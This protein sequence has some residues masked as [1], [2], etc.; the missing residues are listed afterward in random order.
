MRLYQLLIPR[1][2]SYDVMN[3]LGQIDSV[4]IVDQQKDSLAKPFNKYV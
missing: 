3:E 4:M 1:E 2:S